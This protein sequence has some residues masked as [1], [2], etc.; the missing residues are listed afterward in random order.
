MWETC[1]GYSHRHEFICWSFTWGE[2]WYWLGSIDV[3]MSCMC[4][5]IHSMNSPHQ[6]LNFFIQGV[7]CARRSTRS[8]WFPWL[9]V[10]WFGHNLW[11]IAK[12]SWHSLFSVQ[13][14]FKYKVYLRVLR[15]TNCSVGDRECL[16]DF[17][18]Y[19]Q[20]SS[21]LY[22]LAFTRIPKVRKISWTLTRLNWSL[23]STQSY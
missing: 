16:F 6:L 13:N 21:Y 9:H 14:R 12:R 20:S 23:Q 17:V 2:F 15:S 19:L 11:G 18:Q 7:S 8:T 1:F 22:K 5:H 10:H 3:S 4:V